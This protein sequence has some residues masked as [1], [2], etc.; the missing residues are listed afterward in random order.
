M[1]DVDLL[2]LP[3]RVEN[4]TLIEA[5]NWKFHYSKNE[6]DRGSNCGKSTELFLERSIPVHS[7]S[8]R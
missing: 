8:V 6:R 5:S 3:L 1:Y 7:M 4:L 2:C